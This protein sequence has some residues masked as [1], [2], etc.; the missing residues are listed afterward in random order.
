MEILNILFI[1]F[2]TIIA[3]WFA[4]ETSVMVSE[5]KARYRAGTHDHYD[6]LIEE[7]S[8][9]IEEGKR[10]LSVADLKAMT[11]ESNK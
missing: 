10:I 6:N 8:D 9:D 11:M 3:G 5:K 7:E 2:I 1:I 4:W